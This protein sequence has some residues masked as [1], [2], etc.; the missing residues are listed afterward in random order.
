MAEISK[1]SIR[2]TNEN[3][4]LAEDKIPMWYVFTMQIELDGNIKHM[5]SVVGPSTEDT[6]T[7]VDYMQRE[8]AGYDRTVEYRGGF[9]HE[10][11]EEE[12]SQFAPEGYVDIN[13]V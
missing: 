11:S 13:E 5:T 4:Q 10:P 7:V 6:K 1:E 8:I 3:Y 9:D 12:L 2:F